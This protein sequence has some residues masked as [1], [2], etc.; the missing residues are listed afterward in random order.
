MTEKEKRL[1]KR[2]VVISVDKPLTDKERKEF[3]KRIRGTGCA[4]HSDTP[5]DIIGSIYRRF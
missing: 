3:K 1:M 4:L 2:Q 5:T